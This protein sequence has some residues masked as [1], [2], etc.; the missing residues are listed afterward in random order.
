[1]KNEEVVVYVII[2]MHVH[3][4]EK[5]YD[6]EWMWRQWPGTEPRVLTAEQFVD[7]ME[8]STPKIDK[9]VVFG[10]KSLCSE[11]PERMKKDNDYILEVVSEY[12]D[13]YIGAGVIDPSWG[14][15]A[16]S[17]LHRCVNSGIKIVKI[18]YSSMRFRPFSKASIKI[19]KEV[20]KLGVL[21]LIHSD[22]SHF[23]HPI[24][25][26]EIAR[27][28]PDVKFVMQHFGINLS[29]DALHITK[30]IDNLYADTSACS[31]RQRNLVTFVN[32]VSPD[33]LMYGS[34]TGRFRG[35]LQPQDELDRVLSLGLS[36]ELENKIL[37]GNAAMLLSSAGVKL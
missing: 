22:E 30:N 13:R 1:V 18:R 9:A 5:V 16:V 27:T 25:L 37:G 28:F 24:V 12:P 31:T 2:D 11:T 15:K 33:R 7:K 23:S 17:E 32:E 14:N 8:D 34:D 19:L 10:A 4:T 6:S 20:K 36:K 26:G 35:G 29:V 21:P 3:L